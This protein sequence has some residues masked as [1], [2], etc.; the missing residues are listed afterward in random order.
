MRLN[1]TSRFSSTPG[2]GGYNSTQG[3]PRWKQSPR[4]IHSATPRGLSPESNNT[5]A[6]K[7][8]VRVRPFSMAEKND[9][10]R[11]IVRMQNQSTYLIDPAGLGESDED[12]YTREFCYDY[13]Y[14][15]FDKVCLCCNIQ[16]V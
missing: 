7:V 2:Q 9:R 14:W 13:S 11:S 4:S 5:S 6:V 16:A 8:A 10:S 1:R 15:S 12:L 3:T